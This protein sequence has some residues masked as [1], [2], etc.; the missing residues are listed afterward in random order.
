MCVLL[1]KIEFEGAGLARSGLL[2]DSDK[3]KYFRA[4]FVCYEI[5]NTV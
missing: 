2:I 4:L 5:E 3:I 1:R